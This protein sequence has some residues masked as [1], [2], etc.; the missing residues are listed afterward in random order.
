MRYI[1]KLENINDKKLIDYVKDRDVIG[2]KKF[3]EDCI[4]NGIEDIDTKY[5]NYSALLYASNDNGGYEDVE[6]CKILIDAG[7]DV[8]IIDNTSLKNTPLILASYHHYNDVVKIL[9]ESGADWN[10]KD[11][12]DRDFFHYSNIKKELKN[13]YPDEYKEYLIKKDIEKYNL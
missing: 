3:I 8:N 12:Y 4:E 7:A 9:I 11:S 5:N 13:L 1:K 10:K 2:L 6:I